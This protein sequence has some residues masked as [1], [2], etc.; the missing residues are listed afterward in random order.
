M[1]VFS[2][3]FVGDGARSARLGV[4]GELGIVSNFAGDQR[5]GED[6]IIADMTTGYGGDV[7][8][9]GEACGEAR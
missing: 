4:L 8:A 9:R 1:K 7:T 6:G 5:P 3:S 2:G